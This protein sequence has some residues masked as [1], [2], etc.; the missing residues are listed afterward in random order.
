[1]KNPVIALQLYTIRDFTAADLEGT[2]RKVKEMGFNAVELA[3]MY[4]LTAPELKA[5]LDEIGLAAFSA[6]VPYADFE[7]DMEGTIA[8]YKSL[9]CKFVA[10]PYLS[11]S[12]IPGPEGEN[13]PHVRE[14]MKK[15]A[16]LC[17][18]ANMP[19]M[20]HNHAF[21]FEKLENGKYILDEIFSDV[22]G[23]AAELDSGWV[24]AAGECPVAYIKKYAS[25]CP[26]VHLKDTIKVENGFED[27]PVGSGSQD[28]EAII[29][30]AIEC[31]V[32]GFV[33]E[34]DK[35]VGVTSLE[36]AQASLEYLK[37]LGHANG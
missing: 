1:M 33:V 8:A 3:G 16:A 35:A 20:Y 24:T 19:L 32:S 13:W 28:M 10:I 2:L 18:E 4:G 15:S 17:K 7:R 6:H 9:G 11:K 5:L 21:E 25:R 26:V 22:P 37:T 14:V 29:K 30:T 27:R 12:N 31:G 34:L 23:I 36:A